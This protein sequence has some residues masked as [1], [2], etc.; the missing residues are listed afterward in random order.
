MTQPRWRKPT[1]AP[2]VYYSL[3]PT[4][5]EFLRD[6]GD[7][8]LL[9]VQRYSDLN[10]AYEVNFELEVLATEETRPRMEVDFAFM[11]RDG[12]VLGEAKSVSKL[13][14]ASDAER[15]RDAKKLLDA[16]D[17]L[18]AREVCFATTKSWSSA[19]LIAIAR[20]VGETNSKVTVS[21]LER[22]GTPAVSSRNVLHNAG[23]P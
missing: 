15:I 1:D 6:N 18:G 16:A 7:V 2:R 21:T 12:L 9:A 10:R 3:H 4:I 8:P 20:A 17:I 23:G 13:D 14:G 5:E 22:L 19:S 11:S